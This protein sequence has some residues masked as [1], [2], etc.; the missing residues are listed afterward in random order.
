MVRDGID[1]QYNLFLNYRGEVGGLSNTFREYCFV[2]WATQYIP[3]TIKHVGGDE[4]IDTPG[5]YES[6]LSE[7]KCV[8]NPYYDY[9]PAPPAAAPGQPQLWYYVGNNS[10][11][12]KIINRWFDMPEVDNAVSYE[13]SYLRAEDDNWVTLPDGDVNVSFG[14][15]EGAE[16]YRFWANVLHLPEQDEYSF[17]VRAVNPNGVSEWSEARQITSRQ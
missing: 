14:E 15:Y 7:E 16:L 17:R 11:H 8:P 6:R 13:V 9:D 12:V 4:V 1:R 3:P 10:I 5:H 2:V